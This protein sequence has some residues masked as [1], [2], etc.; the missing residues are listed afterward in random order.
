M[1]HPSLIAVGAHD[2]FVVLQ[3]LVW[4]EERDALISAVRS[5]RGVRYVE[6]QLE[7]H[8]DHDNLPELQSGQSRFGEST[9]SMRRQKRFFYSRTTLRTTHAFRTPSHE[10]DRSARV[11][12]KSMSEAHLELTFV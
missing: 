2:G 1:A 3:G 9:A 11:V 4:N 8:D 10:F 7:A 12:T 6:D 5:V